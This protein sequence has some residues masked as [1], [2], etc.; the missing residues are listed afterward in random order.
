MGPDAHSATQDFELIN[1]VLLIKEKHS[2][3][4]RAYQEMASVCKTMPKHYKLKQ[5]V[6]ELNALWNIIPTPNGTLGVQ[7]SLED[8]LIIRVS[9][10]LAI[11]PEDAL[12]KEKTL[13]VK[14]S[15]DGTRIGKRLHVT[16][17]TFTILDE[18]PIAHTS[19]GN[20]ILA[21]VKVPEKHE[22]LKLALEDICHEVERLNEIKVKSETFS[23]EYF[24]GGD[25]KFL[26][27][28]VGIYSA[29][30]KYACPWCKC[31]FDERG[32]LEKV[33]HQ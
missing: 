28:A 13:R 14:L 2:I 29:C 31:S 5:R 6:K 15:G 33:V 23:I 26:A 1:M 21:I 30:S 18:D 19:E 10:L 32:D 16:S 3:S 11:S 7:Q 4:G 22:L 9:K 27:I 24:L 12:F 8:R 20:H 17:F 25:L